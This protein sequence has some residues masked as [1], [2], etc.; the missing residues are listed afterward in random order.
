MKIVTWI[1]RI[2]L[3]AAFVMSAYFKLAGG[4]QVV[5]MFGK[6]GLGQWFLYFTGVTEL[7]GAIL[8]VIPATGLWGALILVATMIGAVATHLFRIGGSPVAAIV[9]GVLAAFVA[10]RLRP[11][12]A[13]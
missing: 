6:I 8:L 10:Y 2:L 1:V 9:L 13:A 4:A 3:A 11:V 7:S 12:K 5:E